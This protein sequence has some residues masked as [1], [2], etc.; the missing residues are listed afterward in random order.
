MIRNSSITIR[1]LS[2]IFS[3]DR[4]PDFF[5][6]VRFNSKQSQARRSLVLRRNQGILAY[7]Q[8]L[9][10]NVPL[11]DETIDT[12]VKFY[13]EDGI[14][15]TSSHSK[16]TIK[17][18]GQLVAVRFMEMTVLDAYR[19][20]NERHPQAIARSTFQTLR[21]REVK[22]ASPHETCMCT[23]HENMDLLLK[24]CVN[25]ILIRLSHLIHDRLGT[26]TIRNAPVKLLREQFTCSI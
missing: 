15:R 22:I 10:G 20:F 3:N 2:P 19:I 18:N 12:V 25:L 23:F 9:R 13:C 17:I 1:S 21:P 16:D 26:I 6:I 24:V 4:S 7:P 8:C 11:S 14:S 5:A